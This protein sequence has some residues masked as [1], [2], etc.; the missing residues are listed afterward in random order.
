MFGINL[1]NPMIGETLKDNSAKSVCDAVGNRYNVSRVESRR[2]GKYDIYTKDGHRMT[3]DVGKKSSLFGGEQ[4]YLKWV[5][6]S[7]F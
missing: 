2:D 1:F 5:E 6:D 7:W 4:T 3:A